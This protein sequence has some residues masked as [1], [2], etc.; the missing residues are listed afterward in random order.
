MTLLLVLVFGSVFL[1]FAL[2]M[3]AGGSGAA[4]ED[5][6][7]LAVLNAAL[8]TDRADR[9]DQMI[10]VRKAELFSAVPLINR[11]LL[12]IELA[13]RL[14]S[15][16]Y[17]AN[18]KWTVGTLLLMCGC[19]CVIP[20]YLVYLRLRLPGVAAIVGAVCFFLP[21][22]FVRQKRA[23]RFGKF[24]QELP[25]ASDMMVN[26]LRAGHSL[27][28]ALG[29]VANEAAE[30][31]GSEFR[32]C[33]EEQNYGL[34]LRTAMANLVARVPL[35]DLR[36]MVAA[37]LI[38]KESGGNLAEVLEKTSELIRERFRL[39]RQVQT[40][41]AQGRMTGW[42]LTFLPIILGFALYLIAPDNI[43]LLWKRDIGIKMLYGSVI[44]IILGAVIIQKIVNI[45]I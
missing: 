33:F 41:T 21:L 22:L 18:L 16:L 8:A 6:K 23:H 45:D 12:K 10:D 19:S 43:S 17:Q 3:I 25:E 40:F 44:M 32:I 11:W 1:V 24:E 2:I 36:I 35:Q 38:Q 14:R 39:K 34:E 30:P 9:A 28:S 42:I 31:V 37:I 26:A 5:K 13:P 15:M 4:R 7:T 27:V 20:A 29:L